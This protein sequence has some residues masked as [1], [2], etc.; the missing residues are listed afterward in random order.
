MTQPF[1][2]G[3]NVFNFPPSLLRIVDKLSLMLW[4]FFFLQRQLVHLQLAIL[5]VH[6]LSPRLSTSIE[7]VEKRV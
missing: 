1:G 3:K 4:Q 6:A 7:H 5:Q 2:V